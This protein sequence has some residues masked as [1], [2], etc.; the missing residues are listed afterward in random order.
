MK[1]S[2]AVVVHDVAPATQPACQRLLKAIDEVAPGLPVTLLVVPR[3]HLAPPSAA[4]I[5]W[6]AGRYARGDE[7]A[8]HGYTHVDD[9]EPHN[10]V[11]HVKRR[12]YTR[13]EGE[14]AALSMTDATRRITAG[15]RWFER[16]AFVLRGFVAPAWLMSEGTWEALRWVDLSY[17]CTLRRLVLLP[18]RRQL[19]SQSVVYSTASAWRRQTSLAW[20]AAVA[21]VLRHN[22][23]LRLELH[24]SDAD[25]PAILRSWQRVLEANVARRRPGTL[26]DVADRFRISTD[27]DLMG[28]G[29]D[30]DEHEPGGD[31]PDR[32]ADRDVAREVQPEDHA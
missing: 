14:F 30:H 26:A 18:D 2:L 23:L 28:T 21:A 20:N 15:M 9:G 7:L 27:W 13:G 32:R 11:D 5:E 16:H 25:H 24:P 10:I 8:L 31:R 22:P 1:P 3:Y 6:I 29:L 17:T 4:F 19:V 12:H